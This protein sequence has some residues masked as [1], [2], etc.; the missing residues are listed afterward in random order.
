MF[1]LFH[2]V[3]VYWDRQWKHFT[4]V[5][6]LRRALSTSSCVSARSW[7]S[8]SFEREDEDV[9]VREE[10][11]TKET[12]GGLIEDIGKLYMT[13]SVILKHSPPAEFSALHFG[14]V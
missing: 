9:G 1:V 12:E 11:D 5:L 7:D 8:K 3:F 10:V 4:S 6:C 13:D 14:A 2:K